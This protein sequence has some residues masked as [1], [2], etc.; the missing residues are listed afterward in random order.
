MA[1]GHLTVHV[2]DTAR[3]VGADGIRFSVERA[4]GTAWRHLKDV[5][6][7]ATGRT[8]APVLAAGEFEPGTY[9][10]TFEAGAYFAAHAVPTADP[11]YLSQV[12]LQVT[13]SADAHHHLPLAISPWGFTHFRGA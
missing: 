12:H 11:P 3:G 6:A 1:A 5:A 4:E 8:D 2:L 7:N 13:L 10:L 9:R